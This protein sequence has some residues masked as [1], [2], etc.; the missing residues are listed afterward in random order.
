MKKTI[1][2]LLMLCLAALLCPASAPAACSTVKI[3]IDQQLTLERIA[4]DARLKVT[5]N[6]PDQSLDNVRVDITIRD[7]AGNDQGAPFFIKAPDCTNISD[8]AGTGSVSPSTEA[9]AHWLIIPSPGAGGQSQ[10]GIFLNEELQ[11]GP[12]TVFF[13]PDPHDLRIVRNLRDCRIRGK[14]Q[15]QDLALE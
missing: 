12:V 3:E 4:F 14:A 9:D 1:F 11:S 5:N 15:P 8:V 10:T 6:L 7:S 2:S 13:L